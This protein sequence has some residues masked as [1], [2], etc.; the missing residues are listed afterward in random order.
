M[1]KLKKKILKKKTA[2]E[3]EVKVE[4]RQGQTLR[5]RIENYTEAITFAEAG[6]QEQAQEIM[7]AELAEA[8]KVLV[9][10]HEDTF[11]KP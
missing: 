3:K 5:E 1:R 11:S 10:G 2:D 4:S 8:A 6:L 7:R 9:V